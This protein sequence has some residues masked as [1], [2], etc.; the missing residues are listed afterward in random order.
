MVVSSL[1]TGATGD[2]RRFDSGKNIPRERA[3]AIPSG[4]LLHTVRRVNRGLLKNRLLR[5]L[6]WED[7]NSS[8]L[9]IIG[10]SATDG[11][12][13]GRPEE[14]SAEMWKATWLDTI[15]RKTVQLCISRGHR[16]R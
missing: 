13:G 3:F 16:R 1:L 5:A 11:V 6:S 12:W 4:A 7:V 2:A 14:S 8:I 15:P 9:E 10:R